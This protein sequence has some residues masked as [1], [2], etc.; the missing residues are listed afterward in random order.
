MP[1]VGP[2]DIPSDVVNPGAAPPSAL[3]VK[4]DSRA[5]RSRP[6]I[7]LHIDVGNTYDAQLVVFSDRVPS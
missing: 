2:I 7:E 6:L 1:N 5:V 3:V 4:M